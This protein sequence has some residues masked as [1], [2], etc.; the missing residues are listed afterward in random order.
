MSNLPAISNRASQSRIEKRQAERQ[1]AQQRFDTQLARDQIKATS[2]IEGARV[3]AVTY[4]GKRAMM[5]AALMSQLEASLVGVVPLAVS[6]IQGL[7]DITAL[8]LAEVVTEAGR[9][10]Q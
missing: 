1:L 8:S 2:E 6:R 9:R 4:V 5:N 7:A 10:M 3:D